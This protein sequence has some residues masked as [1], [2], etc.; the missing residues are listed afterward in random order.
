[1]VTGLRL[2]T[3]TILRPCISSRGTRPLR[4][5]QTV[6]QVWPSYSSVLSVP[7]ASPTLM[8]ETYKLADS[9]GDLLTS[10]LSLVLDLLSLLSGLVSDRL[11]LGLR[12]SCRSDGC[13]SVSST[14]STLSS[15]FLLLL[16]A[17]LLSLQVDGL[18]VEN[19]VVLVDLDL[20]RVLNLQTEEGRV[21]DEVGVTDNVVVSLLTSALLV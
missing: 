17:L 18:D 5:E 2:Q 9:I 10:S 20:L 4:P 19:D 16:L 3:V 13:T 12:S 7:G 6:R 1:M 21:L 14:G 11:L 15:Q 8:V